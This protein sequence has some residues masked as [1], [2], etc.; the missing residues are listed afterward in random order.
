MSSIYSVSSHLAMIADRV[1]TDAYVRALEKAVEPGSTVVDLGA[2]T[3]IFAVIACKLGA[4][5]VYAIEPDPIL[6][7]GREIARQND[8]EDRIE[9]VDA[10]STQIS[11]PK[12]ADVIVAD[13]G[14]A[15]P[16]FRGS[17][18]SLIDA[19]ERLL[20]PGGKLLPQS[21][22]LFAALA[23][24]RSSIPVDHGLLRDAPF[25]VDLTPAFRFASS[26]SF[27][28]RLE[29]SAKQLVTSPERWAEVD[30]TTT[31]EHDVRGTVVSA[32]TAAST[33][34]SVCVWFDRVV[35]EGCTYGNSPDRPGSVY[36]QVLFALR[37]PIN[38][39]AGDTVT[40][41]LAANQVDGFY[42]WRWQTTVKRA[43]GE[44]GPSF[45][46]SS[47][48]STPAP[49]QRL[50]SRSA[51]F[52]PSIG[53]AGRIDAHILSQMDGNTSLAD[54][55]RKTAAKFPDSFD[56]AESAL[57]R[58]ADVSTTYGE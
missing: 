3:A 22:S 1:R 36:G 35:A 34:D 2:G 21:D 43:N 39:G 47:L 54:I 41:D 17:V 11:L 25:G 50:R 8:V 38:L 40:I 10:L 19:R 57:R 30:Y 37:E 51:A 33:A 6:A 55:A 18:S 46:Q 44:A 9:F 26:E 52:T 56:S 15:V 27:P 48:E 4:D 58:I 20:R 29:S 23:D 31:D 53:L 45:S 5:R 42:S 12:P 16:L 28:T 32:A 13:L 7:V 14:G 49:H 24:S